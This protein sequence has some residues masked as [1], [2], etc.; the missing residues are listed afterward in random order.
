MGKNK[1]QSITLA[2]A[3][4]SST[5]AKAQN[6]TLTYTVNDGTSTITKACDT[7][8]LQE[9]LGEDFKHVT[10]LKIEGALDVNDV[11]AIRLMAGSDEYDNSQN[12]TYGQVA[13]LIKE[14][15]QEEKGITSEADFIAYLNSAFGNL[16]VIDLSQASFLALD[17]PTAEESD[18][19]TNTPVNLFLTT[20][21]KDDLTSNYT[22]DIAGLPQV[23][24][25]VVYV[26]TGAQ[27]P[28]FLFS[29][30]DKLEK[31]TLNDAAAISGYA[32]RNCDHLKECTNL[33]G[34]NDK[35]TLIGASAFAYCKNFDIVSTSN[36]EGNLP[37]NL[38]KI[39]NG[40]FSHCS[41]GDPATTGISAVTIPS[42]VTVIDMGAFDCCQ[43]L[44]KL[45]FDGSLTAT[46]PEAKELNISN[47]AF[48]D[49]HHMVIQGD[50]KLPN[51]IVNIL[52]M[53][54][55]NN[56]TPQISLP[57]NSTLTG[58]LHEATFNGETAKEIGGI[59]YGA[60]GWCGK[61]VD[62][63]VPA[64]ITHIQSNV[65][66]DCQSLTNI[67]FDAPENIVSIGGHAFFNDKSLQNQFTKL[68]NVKE[69]GEAAFQDCKLLTNDDANTL[70][71][72][73]TRIENF[74]YQG[75]DLLSDITIN[76]GVDYIGDGAFAND[77][78]LTRITVS[79]PKIEAYNLRYTRHEDAIFDAD[80]KDTGEKKIY[81]QY[82]NVNPF[83]GINA[84]KVQLVFDGDAE[85]NYTNYRN[86]I[87]TT[88]KVGEPT[89]IE[90][91][92]NAF[93]YLLTKTMTSTYDTNKAY[94][95]APQLHADVKFTRTFKAGW[96]TLVLPFELTRT[97]DL[98]Q[99]NGDC[100]NGTRILKEAL[101][102]THNDKFVVSV[103]RG[104]KKDEEDPDKNC[105]MLL[106]YS[107]VWAGIF[108]FEPL[109]IRMTQEDIDAAVDNTYTFTDVDTNIRHGNP[110][111]SYQAEEMQNLI[112]TNF[113]GSSAGDEHPNHFTG[114]HKDQHG[115]FEKCT[116][117]EFFFTG[118]LTTQTIS[119]LSEENGSDNFLRIGDYIIQGNT[120][121]KCE[122]GKSY[123]VKAF[124]GYFKRFT[125]TDSEAAK[126]NIN[127][128]YVDD[129][130]QTTA[131]DEIDG[132]QSHT[133]NAPIYNLSGQL[134]GYDSNALVKGIYICNG[135]KFIVK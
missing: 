35:I 130:G 6:L 87:E 79:S 22:E 60:F 108:S 47:R 43:N 101:N 11:K 16:K 106:K 127:I 51:R 63:K 91:K 129:E 103:Y 61:M 18:E 69:I 42:N 109:L 7:G 29:N 33:V 123:G 67:T 121:V 17:E 12:T 119:D 77:L 131:I 64:N 57:V 135:K 132:E 115:P 2:L 122:S 3:L 80:G 117:D 125:D 55:A 95:V 70:L 48:A 126:H 39:G 38:D 36:T 94:D 52:D 82:D 9:V 56:S 21:K 5:F 8:K 84:N 31:V 110:S 113:N 44:K 14:K 30:C 78:N 104:L 49:C 4:L 96:N 20:T 65:F 107:D 88:N 73:V 68:T 102:T 53:A 24:S 26:N 75:C 120:F 28:E 32:F 59:T 34:T 100:G 134:V 92:G 112:G 74:T 133:T 50:G 62:L 105:F 27:L 90:K 37:V 19:V 98:Q 128:N 83:K 71:S 46:Y 76:K 124:C 25:R 10:T 13:D 86:D 23:V 66:Q 81:W 41:Q 58:Q 111:I 116:Y 54:F 97:R 45:T 72:Q 15:M 1:F 118:K 99:E 93:M 114:N 40:A 85:T 89:N